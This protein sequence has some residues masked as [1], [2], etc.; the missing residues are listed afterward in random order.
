MPSDFRQS[1]AK[2]AYMVESQRCHP[3]SDRFWHHV[4]AVIGSSYPYLQNR[5]VYLRKIETELAI[6]SR[7]GENNYP[8]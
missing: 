4:C 5:G 1:V 8:E 3:S 7:K 6:V 2:N